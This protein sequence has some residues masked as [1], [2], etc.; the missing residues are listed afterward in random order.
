MNWLI[1]NKA[2]P[3]KNT[4][5]KPYEAKP[6]QKCCKCERPALTILASYSTGKTTSHIVKAFCK[7]C[8]LVGTPVEGNK[9]CHICRDGKANVLIH[10]VPHPFGKGS[11][12]FRTH[13]HCAET[14][15][16]R[17]QRRLTVEERRPQC[18]TIVLDP[19]LSQDY[20]RS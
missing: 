18:R 6:R 16:T 17:M 8:L 19:K 9:I 14:I 13:L 12:D 2:D 7:S 3:A 1:A 10:S 4:T 5:G 15:E 20:R 11:Y